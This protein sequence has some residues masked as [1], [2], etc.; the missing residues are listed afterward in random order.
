[1]KIRSVTTLLLL[2]ASLTVA[3]EQRPTPAPPR[4]APAGARTTP[5]L[6]VLIVV[7]QFRGDYV[8]WYGHQ[9]TKG[10]RRLIDT[11]AYFPLAAYRHGV[12]VTCAGH[13]SIGTGAYPRT[14]GMI[15]NEWYDRDAKKRV[16]C[17]DDQSVTPVGFGG[18]PVRE[19]HSARRL[20]I[21]TFAD[22]LRN[23]AAVAPHITSVSLKARSV[24]GMTGHGGDLMVWLED[25]GVWASSS[26]FVK[27]PRPDVDAFADAHAIRKQYGRIWDRLLPPQEYLFADNGV[28]EL[29]PDN[30]TITFPHPQTRPGGA[31]D[32]TFIANWERTPFVDEM[33]TDM[34]LS[35][36]ENFGK[37]TGTDVLNVSF[38]ALDYVGH[39]YGP[40]SQEVQD[41]LARL[42]AQLGRL[43]DTLD[44]RVGAGRYVVAL[45]ADHGVAPIPEQVTA[46]G[47]DA[48]RFTTASVNQRLLEAWK[49]FDTEGASPIANSNGTDIYFTPAAMA[50]FDVNPAARRAMTDAALALPGIAKAYWASDLASG[51]AT[52]DPVRQAMALSFYRGRSAD[53]QLVP[54]AYWMVGEASAATHGTPWTYDQRVPVI[55][56]GW[57]IKAG[58]YLTT[59]A[60]VDI[61]PTLAYLSHISLPRADGR[62][63]SEAMIR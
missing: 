45:S 8:Q 1:M 59:A 17:T 54:K 18:L 39:R 44:K 16:P 23:Q 31:P 37:G 13:S 5:P 25:T 49:P 21:N 30:G 62:V 27:T 19:H 43:F 53:L 10:L 34:A 58:R 4:S 24:I 36:S 12:T 41:V 47:L 22:E 40:K 60:P 7:D 52:D 2:S 32:Q 33:L 50:V 51:A 61:A 15:A 55:L 9:W 3:A 35:F 29:K 57:G 38:S 48:G 11:G 56:M 63:L 26:A 42:D 28:G 14:H 6:V 20:E 46:L